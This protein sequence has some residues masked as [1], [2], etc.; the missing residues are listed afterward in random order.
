MFFRRSVTV[1][2]H[3]DG[4]LGA[5]HRCTVIIPILIVQR[6]RLIV[7]SAR[8]DRATFMA[9]TAATATTTAPTTRLAGF[10]R[11]G[12]GVRGFVDRLFS[13][14]LRHFFGLYVGSLRGLRRRLH[15]TFA[16]R[17]FALCGTRL[18][19]LLR[20]RRRRIYFAL[21]G[22]IVGGLRLCAFL[23]ALLLVALRRLLTRLARCFATLALTL[24]LLLIGIALGA[25]LSLALRRTTAL[26]ARTFVASMI[27]RFRA[28]R[29]R[30]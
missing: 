7:R 16:W 30:A 8:C 23:L 14:G 13:D 4:V 18:T 11:F 10:V 15:R 5:V 29:I 27:L 22:R 21:V 19:L 3:C 12:G 1:V 2:I 6:I 28:L 25:L 9:T 20:F 24:T 17:L 26:V